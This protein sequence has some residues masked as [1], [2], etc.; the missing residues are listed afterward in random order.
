MINVLVTCGGGFQGMT[1]YKSLKNIKG[2][3]LHLF[4]INTENVSKYFFDFFVTTPP[5]KKKR[6]YIKLLESYVVKHNIRFIFP[7]TSFDLD[8]LSELKNKE[9]RNAQ[10]R[11]AICLIICPGRWYNLVL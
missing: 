9:N 6:G 2:T 11:T 10:F 4:D 3:S 5:I 1:L 7:A 8:L